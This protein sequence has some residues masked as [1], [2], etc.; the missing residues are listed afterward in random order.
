MMY[1]AVILLILVAACSGGGTE[2]NGD[3]PVEI[4]D[5][6]EGDTTL[7]PQTI[8]QENPTNQIAAEVNGDVVMIEDVE[9]E[10]TFLMTGMAANAANQQAVVSTALENRINQ[11][12]IEQAAQRMGITITDEAIEAEVAILEQIAAEQGNTVEEFF[13]QQGISAEWYRQHIRESLLAQAVNDQIT[14]A[15]PTTGPQVRARHILVADEATARSLLDQLNQGADFGQLALEYS[16]DPSTREAGGDLGWISPGDLLQAEVEAVIFALPENARSPEPIQS[17]LGYHI[18]ESIERAEDR[19]LDPSRLAE[20]RQQSWD[21]WLAEQRAGATI[22]R[23][24]G[25]NAES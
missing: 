14:G 3:P 25:P 5:N 19:P 16:L 6:A 20:Q 4:V 1:F 2:A 7:A 11:V 24:I 23:Y 22:V 8:I 15:I 12:L 17:I 10:V 9:R 21:E 13:A 18:V